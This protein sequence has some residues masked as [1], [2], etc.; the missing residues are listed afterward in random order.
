MYNQHG[1]ARQIKN[2]KKVENRKTC[3]FPF[4]VFDYMK[5][6]SRRLFLR[7]SKTQN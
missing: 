3:L 7:T 5:T 1:K 2:K 4:L 6:I